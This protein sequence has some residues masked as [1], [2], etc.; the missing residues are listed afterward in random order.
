MKDKL[1]VFGKTIYNRLEFFRVLLK[2]CS[3][4]DV[5][6]L[7]SSLS[8]TTILSL[9]PLLAVLLSVF[10]LSPIFEKFKNQVFDFIINNM[11]PD[12]GD[13]VRVNINS[14][15]AN[16]S[17]TTFIGLVALFAISLLLIR[18]IDITLNKIW[19]TSKKRSKVTTFSVYWT[20][21]TLGPILLGVS[22]A[23][24]SSIFAKEFQGNSTTLYGIN[25]FILSIVPTMLA[26]LI[27]LLMYTTVPIKNVV[28]RYACIGALFAAIAQ[29]LMRRLFM[30]FIM[31][32]SSYTVI[33]GAVAIIPIFMVWTYINWCIVLIGAEISATI[34]EYKVSKNE[35]NNN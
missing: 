22:I 29:D 11:M 4:D 1:R 25:N 18:R 2:R 30:F 6:V 32:F 14:F 35:L 3:D 21:L 20:I 10:S 7:S 15:I 24:I 13:V 26:F 16:A 5:L 12:V 19:H 34:Q 8:Y 28:F 23:I 9:I 27:F 31:N 33:Y 17:E